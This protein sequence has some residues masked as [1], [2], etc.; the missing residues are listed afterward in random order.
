MAGGIPKRFAISQVSPPMHDVIPGFAG[1]RGSVCEKDKCALVREWQKY[2]GVANADATVS[3]ISHN[4]P[5]I[6][7]SQDLATTAYF[8]IL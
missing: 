8:K 7:H 1:V 2:I 4:H 5:D 3:Q 6:V